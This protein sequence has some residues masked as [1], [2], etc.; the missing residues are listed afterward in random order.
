MT[1]SFFEVY[2]FYVPVLFLLPIF[3][4][5]AK[6]SKELLIVLILMGI[7]SLYGVVTERN[8]FDNFLKIY[9]SIVILYSFYYYAV[10]YNNFD[11][12]PLFVK[13]VYFA[14]IV[15]VIGA[16]QMISYLIGFKPGANL[17]WFFNK[18]SYVEAGG[19]LRVNSI[20][21]EPSQLAFVLAPAIFIA[22]YNLTNKKKYF[23]NLFT[24][25]LILVI[26]VLTFSTH[27]YIVLVLCVIII[28]MRRVSLGK[29]L[30]FLSVL[31]A[32]LVLIYNNVEMVR[33]RLDDS[34]MIANDYNKMANSYQLSRL[35]TSSFTLY[36][37]ALVSI[38]SF[39]S[40]PLVG[41]GLG[42]HSISFDKYSLTNQYYLPFQDFNKQDANS[43]GLRIMSELGLLG[44]GIFLYILIKFRVKRT[45]RDEVWIISHSIL[46]MMLAA[47]LR[48]GHY[49][50]S[51]VP[52]FI[53]IYIY[54]KRSETTP[55][56]A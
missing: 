55:V 10:A 25:L 41:S 47:L 17:N 49:F 8:T 9:L 19:W 18:W 20:I 29:S 11:V 40:S 1:R 5:H 15:T 53:F 45:A 48:E 52:L 33:I 2:L 38:K 36:N 42:S 31:T 28:L 46:V 6:Y 56:N 26:T 12:F 4:R 3:F 34:F 22:I 13:Y 24:S 30:V 54:I 50:I 44:L 39:E 51:G 23:F 7:S 43:L 14:R 35:N 21:A 37:N 32:L 16:L 27:A